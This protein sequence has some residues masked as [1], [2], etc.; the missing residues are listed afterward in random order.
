MAGGNPFDPYNIAGLKVPRYKVALYG[1]IGYVALLT[2]VIQYKKMQ[3]PAP[4]VYESKEE[5][6]Y[7]KRYIQHMEGELK[8]PVLVRQPFTGPSFI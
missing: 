8:K 1:I 5:E 3:P 7:V 2:G 4:I 6:G